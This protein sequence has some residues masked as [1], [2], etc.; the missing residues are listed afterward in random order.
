MKTHKAAITAIV[1]GHNEGHLLERCLSSLSFCEEIIYIDLESQDPSVQIAQPLAQKVITQERRTHVE[2]VIA[3]N[4]HLAKNKWILLVDPDEVV[5]KEL[6][7]SIAVTLSGIQDDYEAN[8]TVSSVAVPWRFRVKGKP[9]RGTV[10]GVQDKKKAILFNTDLCTFSDEIHRGKTVARGTRQIEIKNCNGDNVLDHF[11]IES[12]FSFVKKMI[13]YVG[14]ERGSV[15]GKQP[16]LKTAIQAPALFLL[17][18]HESFVICNGWKSGVRGFSLS[19]VWAIY[20]LLVEDVQKTGRLSLTAL[21]A[22]KLKSKVTGFA[23]RLFEQFAWLKVSEV[24][25]PHIYVQRLTEESVHTYLR[26]NPRDVRR[27]LI[28][29]GYLGEEVPRIL[30]FYPNCKIDIYE[31][32]VRYFPDLAET[33]SFHSNVSV[34]NM[35]LGSKIGETQ[36]YETNLGGSGSLLPP[37]RGLKRL[38]G[39]EQAE[40]FTVEVQTI[41]NLYPE[42]EYI[43]LLQLDVQGAELQVLKGAEST[44]SRTGAVLLEFS[45]EEKLYQSQA[46]LQELT[47]YMMSKEFYLAVS[48]SDTSLTGNALFVRRPR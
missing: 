1:V 23:R 8:M 30:T 15:D 33:Y 26:N 20:C 41:D 28:V 46:L 12:Y 3:T 7:E 45:S 42:P 34:F 29:G 39:G 14:I 48:G 32:S 43:D 5:T 47:E 31:P 44:L 38:F 22:R 13:R 35:A 24:I 4:V 18:F 36:F 37:D 16:L 9:L 21:A 27:W 11:W 2:A 25:P 40:V 10:W 19:I 17:A 6:G